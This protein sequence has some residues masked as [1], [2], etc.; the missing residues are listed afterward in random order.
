[1]IQLPALLLSSKT[2]FSSRVS[3]T[4]MG[5][6]KDVLDMA[7]ICTNRCA[8]GIAARW[9]EFPPIRAAAREF[10]GRVLPATGAGDEAMRLFNIAYSILFGYF[11]LLFG[12]RTY[13][14]F[15]S[16]SLC[17]GARRVDH[18]VY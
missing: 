12:L 18:V 15:D 5:E 7:K 1:M 4:V 16:A 13:S 9:E 3:A 17:V 8:F 14:L 6:G 11:L 2:L 10:Y